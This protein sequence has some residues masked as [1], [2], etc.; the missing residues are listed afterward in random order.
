MRTLL[1]TLAATAAL[2]GTALA[3][4]GASVAQIVYDGASVSSYGSSPEGSFN[5]N[6]WSTTRRGPDGTV[7][8]YVYFSLNRPAGSN[9]WISVSGSG[10]VPGDALKATGGRIHVEIADLVAVPDFFMTVVRCEMF[11]CYEEPPPDAFPVS[12]VFTP[13]GRVS[14]QRHGVTRRHSEFDWMANASVD[15]VEVGSSTAGT[16]VAAGRLG[17]R[18]IP[19]AGSYMLEAWIGQARGATITIE[20]T[21]A[22]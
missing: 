2:G 22:R 18:D 19:L 21:W 17:D 11:T 20:R 1:A 7:E 12:L 6:A 13:S 3:Q 8:A 9:S 14:E 5:F 10:Y 4:T 15:V 16:A